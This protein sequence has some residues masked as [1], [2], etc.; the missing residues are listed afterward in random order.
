MKRSHAKAIAAL[1]VGATTAAPA[2]AEDA[3]K[4]QSASMPSLAAMFEASGITESGYVAASYYGSNGYPSNVHQFD[5]NH[6]TFQVDQVGLTLGF[7]PKSGFGVLVDVIAGEDA[8]ILHAAEDGHNDTFDLKQAYIQYVS[9]ALTLVLGKFVTLAGEEVIAPPGNANFS[10]SLLFFYCEPLTHTG[11]RATYAVNDALS[12]V[13]GVNNGWNSTS[14]SYSPKTG[15]AGI[16]WVPS[17]VFS[18][19]AQAYLGKALPYDA[20]KALVDI[21]ATYNMTSSLTLIANIDWNEQ[22]DAFGS[23]NGAKWG[24]VAGYANYALNEQWRVSLRGE[25]LDDRDGFLTGAKQHLWEGT[26]TF[27]YSPVKSFELRLEGRH[28]KAKVDTF[29]RTA[30][31]LAAVTPDGDSLTGFAVQGVYKF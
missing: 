15:E 6:N 30:A 11:I 28:D 22:K 9:G 21:V 12:L 31:G 7:Q 3:G 4:P 25:Y 23:D 17:K 19:T 24:G 27:G 14:T 16:A 10:R 26:I 13:A 18:L 29:Y 8:R 2:F 20:K 1:L 5:V